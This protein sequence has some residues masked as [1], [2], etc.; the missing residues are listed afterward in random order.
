MRRRSLGGRFFFGLALAVLATRILPSAPALTEAASADG[1]HLLQ[2]VIEGARK[3][4]QLNL[5]IYA[6]VGEKGASE[7]VSAFK[8][9][10]SLDIRLNADLSGQESQKFNQA[11]AESKSG[12]SPTF[13]IMQGE[14]SNILSLMDAGGAEPIKG[15]EELLAEVAPEAYKVK[16]KISPQ[17]L[18]G[19]GFLWS[20]RT[21][22]LLYNPKLISEADLPKTWKQMGDPKYKGAFTMPPWISALLMAILKY[23]RE[24][25]LEIVRALGRN[26]RDILTMD[27]AA[28]RMMLGEIKFLHAYAG[29]YFEQKSRDPNAPIGEAFFEDSTTMGHVMYVMRKGT[30]NPNAA[31]LFALWATGAE[32]NDIFEKYA[33][34]ENLVLRQ[35][36]VTRKV[37]SAL[38]KKNIQPVSWFD[39]PQTVEK[40]RWLST[41]EVKQYANLIA[42][43]Q[44]EGK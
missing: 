7:L 18:A 34:V 41:N 43:A 6:S 30:K 3:E 28:Q 35:G 1:K 13:D 31:K 24:E 10:F 11:V 17:I 23:D 20:T 22:A 44:R 42:K 2:Q 37:V 38:E 21:L 14:A 5:R 36:P 40:F 16:E 8:R 32:A 26:K 39:S 25:W 33:S 27:A 12:I 19:Y 4:G 9:R 15:W 29:D